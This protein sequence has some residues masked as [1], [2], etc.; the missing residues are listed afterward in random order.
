[1]INSKDNKIIIIY[2]NRKIV[3]KIN[4]M[5]LFTRQSK[6]SKFHKLL[7][8]KIKRI[9]KVQAESKITYKIL[10][11]RIFKIYNLKLKSFMNEN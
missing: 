8:F 4:L 5:L 10:T 1:M 9:K 7:N 6:I 11:Y 3:I 2:L